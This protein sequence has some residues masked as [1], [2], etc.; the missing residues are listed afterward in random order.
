MK[1]FKGLGKRNGR[2]KK[3]YRK[4][5][6]LPPCKPLKTHN[7][8]FS[9]EGVSFPVK[10]EVDPAV[11]IE[12]IPP[13]PPEETKLIP[14]DCRTPYKS[15]KKNGAGT[16]LEGGRLF[17]VARSTYKKTWQMP[18]ELVRSAKIGRFSLNPGTKA[19]ARGT[20]DA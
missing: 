13:P 2:Y 15:I 9:R 11:D 4:P 18:D 6:G 14:D 12:I 3:Y 5:K 8:S 7:L 19:R 17:R 1:K 20:S 16:G 10:V